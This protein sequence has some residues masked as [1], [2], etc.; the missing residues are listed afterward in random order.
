ME[1]T[2]TLEFLDY[3]VRWQHWKETTLLPPSS[4]QIREFEDR[5]DATATERMVTWSRAVG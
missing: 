3:E 1:L 2:P 5:F 4:E